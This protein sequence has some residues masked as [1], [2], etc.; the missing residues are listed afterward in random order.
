MEIFIKKSDKFPCF[1]LINVE[2]GWNQILLI[3]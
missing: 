2:E 1:I 3:F